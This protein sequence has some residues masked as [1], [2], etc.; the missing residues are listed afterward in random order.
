MGKNLLKISVKTEVG[1]PFEDDYNV[2]Q[3]VKHLLD[4]AM[5]NFGYDP[6]RAGEYELIKG[7]SPLNNDLSLEEAGLIDG[8]VVI[9]RAKQPLIDG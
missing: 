9:L 4:K 7:T 2:H 3:K 1:T 5:Q 8:D 6:S